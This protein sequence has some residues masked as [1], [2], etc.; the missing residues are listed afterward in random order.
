MLGSGHKLGQTPLSVGI[1]Y[2]SRIGKNTDGAKRLLNMLQ[3]L[4]FYTILPHVQQGNAAVSDAWKEKRFL[5][6]VGLVQTGA[7]ASSGAGQEESSGQ[8]L[9]ALAIRLLCN[10]EYSKGVDTALADAVS[11]HPKSAL[12]KEVFAYKEADTQASCSTGSMK[13]AELEKARTGVC[14]HDSFVQLF[15]PI[16][17]SLKL[18]VLDTIAKEART[19][20]GKSH[21]MTLFES[22][23][24]LRCHLTLDVVQPSSRK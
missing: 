15:Q 9:A 23:R 21:L 22:S 17:R 20:L 4:L 1:L 11:Q 13:E 16:P 6:T 12:W 10:K 3:T 5:Q 8:L 7:N 14:F 2:Y 18:S 19:I 24:E